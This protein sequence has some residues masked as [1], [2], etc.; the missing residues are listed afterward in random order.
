MLEQ[1]VNG[2]R[3]YTMTH[4][5][6]VFGLSRERIRQINGNVGD[7][8]MELLKS[9]LDNIRRKLFFEESITIEQIC[10]DYRLAKLTVEFLIGSQHRYEMSVGKRK[11]DRCKEILPFEV[12]Y[13]NGAGVA[14]LCPECSTARHSEWTENNRE[15]VNAYMREY[16]KTPQRKSYIKKYR[17]ERQNDL[18]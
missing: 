3:R 7:S 5:G 13:K 12:F 6:K 8:R 11:C 18:S 1:D 15:H 4:V 2:I 14:R 10:K 9:R 16:N 17:E